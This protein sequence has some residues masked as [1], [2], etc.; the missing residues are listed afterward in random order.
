MQLAVLCPALP[1]VSN[2]NIEYSPFAAI[3]GGYPIGNRARISCRWAYNREGPRDRYCRSNRRWS[4]STQ[5]C[6]RKNI[7]QLIE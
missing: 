5:R 7:L 6:K 4:G 1:S 3:S 2:G